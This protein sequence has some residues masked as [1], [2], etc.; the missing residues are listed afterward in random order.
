MNADRGILLIADDEEMNKVLLSR[1][2]KKEG[3]TTL[4]ASDG[5]EV[6]AKL[7]QLGPDHLPRIVLMDINMPV[8]DG[9]ETT[10]ILKHEFAQLPIIAVT[11]GVFLPHEISAYGFDDFCTKP[12]DFADL[13]GKIHKLLDA[14]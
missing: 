13:M 5:E 8:M 4:D 14:S 9:F 7:R 3:F 6:L 12:I 11:A 1:R 2:L 10:K